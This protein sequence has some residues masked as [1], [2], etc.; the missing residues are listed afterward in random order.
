[1]RLGIYTF[2]EAGEGVDLGR[3]MRRLVEEIKLADEVGLDVES[4]PLFGYD[5]ELYDELFAEKLELLPAASRAGDPDAL[6]PAL[7]PADDRGGHRATAHADVAQLARALH[8]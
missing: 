3:R 6:Q 5:L 7:Y 2:G 1:M 4:F 8:S